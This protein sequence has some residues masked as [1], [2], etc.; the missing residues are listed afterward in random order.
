[1]KPQSFVI[2][3]LFGILFLGVTV[4]AQ[5]SGPRVPYVQRDICPFECCQYGQWTARSQLKVYKQEGASSIVTFTIK[6]GEQ[7]TALTG[8]IHTKPGIAVINNS[9]D[10]FI[11]GDKVYILSYRG[12]GAYDLWYKGKEINLDLNK[13]DV[14]WSSSEWIQDPQM[15][16]WVL[17]ENKQ[18]RKGWLK[19]KNISEGGFR[20]EEQINGWDSCS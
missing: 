3:L 2:V 10:Q 15:T 5:D 4:Y 14:L 9:F 20:T 19:L 12:E 13:L 7:F 11:K 8:S 1:M 6:P 17:I 16:W 18:G